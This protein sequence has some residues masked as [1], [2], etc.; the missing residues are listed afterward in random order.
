MEKRGLHNNKKGVDKL[1]DI[2]GSIIK[3]LTD[4]Q[5]EILYLYHKPLSVIKIANERSTSRNAVY[6]TLNKL[7][8]KGIDINRKRG[9]TFTGGSQ[10]PVKQKEDIYRLHFQRFTI[11]I[12]NKTQKYINFLKNTNKTI[13]NSNTVQFYNNRIVIY[14]NISFWG[15]NVDQCL[16]K[17]SIYWHKFIKLIEND[18]NLTLLKPRRCHIKDFGGHIAKTN[19]PLAKDVILNDKSLKVLS[20]NG[21]LR[22]IIDNSDNLFELETVDKETAILDMKNIELMYKDVLENKTYLPSEAKCLIDKIS[23]QIIITQ[24]QLTQ[25]IELQNNILKIITP[26]DNNKNSNIKDYGNYFN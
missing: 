21:N 4:E 22:L 6:K 24:T 1:V 5:I 16:D 3:K 10:N 26:K 15:S 13:R 20:P 17:S 7:K 18:Y 23:K 25:S 11:E 14:S 8:K 19:D 9:L 2:Y 12:I